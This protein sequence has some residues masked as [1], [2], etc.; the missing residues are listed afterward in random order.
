M[1]TLLPF[2]SNSANMLKNAVSGNSK[3][4]CLSRFNKY[5]CEKAT[6]GLVHVR[7]KLQHTS[8]YVGEKCRKTTTGLAHAKNKLQHASQYVGG[9]C[10]KVLPGSVLFSSIA[11]AATPYLTRTVVLDK[12]LTKSSFVALHQGASYVDQYLNT[13]FQALGLGS[14]NILSGL[15]VMQHAFYKAPAET[16]RALI[17]W[18]TDTMAG[19]VLS[20]SVVGSLL[21]AG[22]TAYQEINML[23]KGEK[24]P[25]TA[26]QAEVKANYYKA[27]T[28][29][30]LMT[31]SDLKNMLFSFIIS[32][33]IAG[34]VVGA[35][36]TLAATGGRIGVRQISRLYSRKKYMEN[37]IQSLTKQLESKADLFN[38]ATKLASSEEQLK[39]A[40]LHID[41]MDE[42]LILAKTELEESKKQQNSNQTKSVDSSTGLENDDGFWEDLPGND[43]LVEEELGAFL[44]NLD[45]QTEK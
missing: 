12:L 24:I 22:I 19:K 30:K 3:N 35:V 29:R 17:G 4:S 39:S 43:Q 15:P 2:F 36:S 21:S 8:Q 38:C 14:Q 44:E 5:A 18:L 23:R 31:Y 27:L 34:P 32:S 41:Y 42:Q 13:A 7:N 6:T 40:Q 33:L 37:K 25:D 26:D 20:C 28:D 16:S 9:K 45:Q 11:A 1:D 10:R